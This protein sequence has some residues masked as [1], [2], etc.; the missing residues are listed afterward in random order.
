MKKEL[1]NLPTKVEAIEREFEFSAAHVL[2]GHDKCGR[3]HGHN[4]KG[5]VHIEGPMAKDGMIYDYNL[6]S[7]IIENYDHILILPGVPKPL[8]GPLKDFDNDLYVQWADYVIPAKDVLFISFPQTTAENI[9]KAIAYDVVSTGIENGYRVK[10][11]TVELW[12]NER[13][14]VLVTA[15]EE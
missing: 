15:E 11:V 1:E 13:S 9:A 14:S 6:I 8:T 2:L 3:I 7:K 5:T 12:E 4:Y 10:K